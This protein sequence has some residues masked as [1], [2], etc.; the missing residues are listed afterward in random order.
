M[1]VNRG[2]A[3]RSG[4][5]C[6]LRLICD[7]SRIARS[8]PTSSSSLA[9]E[10]TPPLP[11]GVHCSLRSLRLTLRSRCLPHSLADEKHVC[12]LDRPGQR[13]ASLAHHGGRAI[14]D[15]RNLFVIAWRIA[16]DRPRIP[17]ALNQAGA[18]SFR[19][20]T[21]PFAPELWHAVDGF[22]FTDIT[23]HRAV[24]PRSSG[25]LSTGPRYATRSGRTPLMSST[26][27]L[28]HARMSSDVGAVLLT[29]NGPS[30]KDGGWAFCSG[31][32]QR[33]RGRAGYQYDGRASAAGDDRRPGTAAHPR[34]AAADPFHAEGGDRAGQRLGGRRWAQPACG[35]R[36]VA[37]PVPSMPGSSR[38]TPM[39]ARSTAGFGS[40]YLARQ[41]GQKF[42]REIFFLGETYSAEDA[43]RMGMVNRVVPHADLETR[44]LGV[45]RRSFAARARLR[46]G[47]S[48][49]PSMQSMTA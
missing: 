4:L 42:A 31:G 10:R 18:A 5:T 33:I 37:W 36:P 16:D 17:I 47:C 25:S 23:Y 12:S 20:V 9:E 21:S 11:P 44:R 1:L 48:S 43:Y 24:T 39:S 35:L 3:W 26:A 19:G 6:T 13:R 15:A 7:C 46:S 49:S 29:G 28:D 14:P 40:A 34:G 27:A 41:V 38:P 22:D 8:Y 45:G 2:P 32:D 30:P